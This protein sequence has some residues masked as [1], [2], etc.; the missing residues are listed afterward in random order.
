[1]KSDKKKNI[2]ESYNN[3]SQFYDERYNLLQIEKFEFALNQFNYFGKFVLDAGCGTGLLYEFITLR[4]NEIHNR[5]VSVDISINM[6][7]K[8]KNK[9]KILKKKISILPILSDIE[10][11][12]IR[13]EIFDAVV[14]FTSLQN[15]EDVK[16]GF[17]ELIRVSKSGAEINFSILKKDKRIDSLVAYFKSFLIDFYRSTNKN[18]EDAF[19]K[20]IVSK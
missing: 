2:I 1:M 3:S 15:L 7:K 8:L 4:E 11:L 10:N 13:N 5:F 18:L 9:Q 6:L 14:S 12:P 20:G 16:K 17:S 19:I